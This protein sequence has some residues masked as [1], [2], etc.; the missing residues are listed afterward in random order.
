MA[1]VVVVPLVHSHRRVVIVGVFSEYVRR[2]DVL[3]EEIPLP[4]CSRTPTSSS[5]LRAVHVITPEFNLVQGHNPKSLLSVY[6]SP[7][8]RA[9]PKFFLYLFTSCP[10]PCH[11]LS[12]CGLRSQIRGKLPFSSSCPNSSTDQVLLATLRVPSPAYVA[13]LITQFSDADRVKLSDPGASSLPRSYPT[14]A[15]IRSPHFPSPQSRS[16]ERFHHS[17]FHLRPPPN[18][19]PQYSSLAPSPTTRARSL[20]VRAVRTER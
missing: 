3:G 16:L 1:A 10:A 5:A 11:S 14:S 17:I 18:C 13:P 2:K 15:N 8:R 6:S 19:R 9:S 7:I 20:H 4:P 12:S